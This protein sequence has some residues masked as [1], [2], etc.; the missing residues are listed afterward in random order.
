MKQAKY[1]I[2][3]EEGTADASVVLHER[4]SQPDSKL[5]DRRVIAR[6][7]DPQL[8]LTVRQIQLFC[9]RWT[10]ASMAYVLAMVGINLYKDFHNSPKSIFFGVVILIATFTVRRVAQAAG[11]YVENESQARLSKLVD[12]FYFM[13]FAMTT[14]SFII[15]VAYLITLF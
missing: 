2:I 7:S 3:D 5:R 11:S 8:R 1:R 15:G 14:T 9:R 6:I 12:C 13:I 10:W 4:R